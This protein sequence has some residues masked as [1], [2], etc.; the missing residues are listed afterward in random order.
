MDLGSCRNRRFGVPA[1][2]SWWQ[3]LAAKG[4]CCAIFC[5]WVGKGVVLM[6][7]RNSFLT[8]TYT[9]HSVSCAANVLTWLIDDQNQ[10]GY[11]EPEIA[12]KA[13]NNH[14]LAEGQM[15]FLA[16][17]MAASCWRCW[18]L[19]SIWSSQLLPIGRRPNAVDFDHDAVFC[20]QGLLP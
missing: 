9:T 7:K 19:T 2:L 17:Q 10:S 14:K 16:F 12:F 6:R 18:S 15:P 20:W 13:P 8:K 4:I 11:G 3:R 5:G 1:I